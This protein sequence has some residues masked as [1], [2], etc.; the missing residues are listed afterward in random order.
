MLCVAEGWADLDGISTTAR[1]QCS[2]G[3]YATAQSI[4]CTPCAA[5]SAA[6]DDDDPSTPCL[7]LAG[8]LQECS[9]GSPN[10]DCIQDT[11]CIA[12][13]AGTFSPGDA[14]IVGDQSICTNCTMG[15]TDDDSDPTTPCTGC[16]TSMYSATVGRVA[17]CDECE[18]GRFARTVGTVECDDCSAGQFASTGQVTCSF[19]T[20]GRSDHDSDPTTPCTACANGTSVR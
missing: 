17:A 9:A 16:P 12:C 3:T 2:G 15:R 20:A 10:H 5:G 14:R 7:A 1:E 18:P 19:C 13:G 4:D 6:A 11:P 8:C